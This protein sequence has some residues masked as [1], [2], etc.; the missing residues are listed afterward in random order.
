ML[1]G[2]GVLELSPRPGSPTPLTPSLAKDR[3]R[4]LCAALRHWSV[5][6]AAHLKS[7]SSHWLL[8]SL[9]IKPLGARVVEARDWTP[10]VWPYPQQGRAV[11]TAGRVGMLEA[12]GWGQTHGETGWGERCGEPWEAL[13]GTSG[14]GSLG[15]M[16]WGEGCGASQRHRGTGGMGAGWREERVQTAYRGPPTALPSLTPESSRLCLSRSCPT[17]H[18]WPPCAFPGQNAAPPLPGARMQ[19]WWPEV[20]KGLGSEEG[21]T[22]GVPL[23]RA[24]GKGKP[25]EG[26]GR[27]ESEHPDGQASPAG[28]WSY[29]RSHH[30]GKTG[31]G[32]RFVPEDT[33][34][35]GDRAGLEPRPTWGR[36]RGL[37]SLQLESGF[38]APSR[39][40]RRRGHSTKP[41]G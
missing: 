13:L 16:G 24:F 18:A 26:R 6:W 4:C 41:P 35:G 11:R 33:Q 14:V 12:Q 10:S 7:E 9:E 19:A 29:S 5:R 31:Q 8:R 25:E 2:A 34:V 32:G 30:S 36:H 1:G 40:P 27:V 3:T 38:P 20:T 39:R 21:D 17:G 37:W 15:Q 23:R 28:M 22:G